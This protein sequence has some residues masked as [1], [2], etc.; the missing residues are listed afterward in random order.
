MKILIFGAG[1]IG[2]YLGGI[3]TIAR[4]DVTLVARGAQLEA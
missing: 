1:A 4:A 2:G 3:V